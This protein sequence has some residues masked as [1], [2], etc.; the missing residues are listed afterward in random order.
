MVEVLCAR[1]GS[2]AEGLGKAPLPGEVGELVRT[3]TCSACWSE[4]K[5]AQVKL[6]NEYQLTPVN[7]E[8]YDFLVKEMRKFLA[9]G[10][11]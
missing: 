7:P 5:G 9:L 11:D 6:L 10:D 4:W 3:K 8:H 2:S 1:C